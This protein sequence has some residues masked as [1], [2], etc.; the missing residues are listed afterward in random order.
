[1]RV[2][3][4]PAALFVILLA[5]FVAVPAHA[6]SDTT[7][8]YVSPDE[9]EVTVPTTCP[10]HLR[11]GFTGWIYGYEHAGYAWDVEWLRTAVLTSRADVADYVAVGGPHIESRD[12]RA[13]WYNAGI[14][15]R[16]T[17]IRRYLFGRLI[18]SYERYRVI[19]NFGAVAPVSSGEGCGG[20]HQ[21]T[22][23]TGP[24]GEALETYSESS[25]STQ[26]SCG[27]EGGG[28]GDDGEDSGHGNT[29]T[30][31]GTFAAKC[32]NLGGRLYYDIIDLAQWDES[33]GEWKVVW[34]GVAAICET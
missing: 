31:D 16:C 5:G 15:V 3:N 1:M 6:Q 21:Y 10:T 28:T 25:V 23:G 14:R 26:S 19:A 17:A 18:S 34:S 24:G 4:R 22:M 33:T 29:D 12:G 20:D 32:E 13:I 7:V 30:S 11:G 8:F 9:Y 27:P 2:S